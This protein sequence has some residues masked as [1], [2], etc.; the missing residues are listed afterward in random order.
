MLL[1][2]QF[3]DGAG[4]DQESQSEDR[5]RGLLTE[6]FLSDY[7][8]EEFASTE[9]ELFQGHHLEDIQG[10]EPYRL[11]LTDEDDGINFD[12]AN[13]IAQEL[14]LEATHIARETRRLSQSMSPRKRRYRS[15]TP[16]NKR[17]RTSDEDD[18]AIREYRPH[19][20]DRSMARAGP[21]RPVFNF[22][23]RQLGSTQVE[24][25]SQPHRRSI[26]IRLPSPTRTYARGPQSSVSGLGIPVRSDEITTRARATSNLSPRHSTSRLDDLRAP[27]RSF[28]TRSATPTPASS[29]RYPPSSCVVR[30][31]TCSNSIRTSNIEVAGVHPSFGY[32]SR[33]SAAPKGGVDGR[34]RRA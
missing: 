30:V 4:T 19:S 6:A 11:S 14:E 16:S 21:L 17:R 20:V 25:D 28:I 12:L 15:S 22:A 7:E 29:A 13:E 33:R 27:Q 18:W 9:D 8:G 34:S 3:S 5:N 2:T 23:Q 32:I 10:E 31:H 1:D 26:P 24:W